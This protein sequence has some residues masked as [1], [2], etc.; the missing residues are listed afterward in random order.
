[1]D[2]FSP[3]PARASSCAA[4]RPPARLPCGR[5]FTHGT[6]SSPRSSSIRWTRWSST[7][8]MPPSAAPTY[9]KASTAARPGRVSTAPAPPGCPIFPPIPWSSIPAIHSGF[10]WGPTWEFSSR[11]TGARPGPSRTPASLTSSPSRWSSRLPSSLPSLTGA[12]CGGLRCLIDRAGGNLPA[13]SRYEFLVET[14][15]TERLKT[16]SV[17]SQLRDEDL[18]F[19][20]E[21]RARTPH[22]HMVHQCVS[23]DTW[24]KNMLGIDLGEPP[25]P[26]EETRLAFLRKYAEASGRRLE[27]LRGMPEDWFEGAT[28]FFDVERPRAWV[29]TRRIA[30]SAHHRGQLTAYLR[31]LGRSLYST[32]GPTAD[33][34]G[35]ALN[36]AP[37]LYRYPDLD[38]L[39]AAE[40]GG[41][42]SPPLPG[43]GAKSP[44]E[45][46]D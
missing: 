42:E 6:A 35:L 46:R 15:D 13:M 23:E 12:A 39:L 31:L 45:R 25:L 16:L 32:Y 33:T 29:L 41:G 1:M 44:T 18:R 10:T 9:G 21:P 8:P 2:T 19:R 17:W 24:L 3:A 36:G 22:E 34:G 38:R 37:T 27:R 20:P 14:Y 4:T 5:R 26:A 43:P 28:R 30:H 40:D 11:S 7:R